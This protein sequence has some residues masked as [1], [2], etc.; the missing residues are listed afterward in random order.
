MC[1]CRNGGEHFEN[2][3]VGVRIILIWTSGSQTFSSHRTFG[4][5]T[6]LQDGRS[7][8]R[9]PMKWIFQFTTT[10]QPHKDPGFDSASNRNEYRASFWGV[11]GGRRLR[12]TTLPPLVSRLFRKCG[13]LD[14]S[15]PYGPP[16]PVTGIALPLPYMVLYPTRQ[17]C[18]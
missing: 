6:M 11:K 17:N 7:R 10:F 18:T 5:G 1:S 16:W 9:V 14:V 8:D 12:L 3:G 13:S 2:L 15:Q 4:W